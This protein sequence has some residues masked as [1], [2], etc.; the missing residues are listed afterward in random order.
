M[1]YRWPMRS[2]LIGQSCCL[3]GK[4][5]LAARISIGPQP[6]LSLALTSQALI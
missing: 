6:S 5:E 1:C 4:R 3:A 2:L